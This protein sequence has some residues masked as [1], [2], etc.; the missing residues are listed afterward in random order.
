MS[1]QYGRT[2]DVNHDES[3]ALLLRR[4]DSLDELPSPSVTKVQQLGRQ[5]DY[6]WP[7][8]IASLTVQTTDAAAVKPEAARLLSNGSSNIPP[9]PPRES[10][11]AQ[12][13]RWATREF[14]VYYAVVIVSLLAMAYAP[15][16]LSR[17]NS[18]TKSCLRLA[19]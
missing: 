18:L 2:D 13:S 11:K 5:S 12:P 10:R 15:V 17:G 3:E 19:R 14:F 9:R 4:R 6:F 8:G 16:R 1:S 7:A